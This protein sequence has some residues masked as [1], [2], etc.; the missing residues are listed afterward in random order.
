MAAL[1][2][3]IDSTLDLWNFEPET[4][5]TDGTAAHAIE[6][7]FALCV[8]HAGYRIATTPTSRVASAHPYPFARRSS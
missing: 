6:R 4:G 7:M 3:L 2:P 5:R 8:E 1:E